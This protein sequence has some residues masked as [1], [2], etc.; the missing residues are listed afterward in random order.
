MIRKMACVLLSVVVLIVSL[1]GCGGTAVG[2]AAPSGDMDANDKFKGESI[3]LYIR[4]MDA[5]D[6]WFRDN[7]IADFQQ[8]YG[9]DVTVKTFET[10]AE[11]MHI[12]QMDE[13]KSGIGVVK[14]PESSVFPYKLGG[15]S[16]PIQ[17]VPNVDMEAIKAKY[18]ARALAAV[19]DA[20]GTWG[21]PRK[22]ENMTLVYVKSKVADAVANW[23]S[24]R[25]LIEAAFAAENGV[26]LPEGYALEADPNEWDWYDLAVVGLYWANTEYNGKTQ[27]RIAH[28]TRIYE[29]TTVELMNKVYAIGGTPDD[30]TDP[31]SSA[32]VETMKWEIFSVKNNI[33]L[34]TMWEE[35]WSGGGIWNAFASGD[36][37]LAFM[38]QMD[39]FFIHGGS[40]PDMP[41]YLADPDDMGVAIMPQGASLELK[42][43]QPAVTGSHASY[44]NGWYWMIPKTAPNP[45]LSLALIEFITS[46]KYHMAEA[47]TFGIMPVTNYVLNNLS[48]LDEP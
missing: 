1:V 29:G 28:R 8:E 25:G 4:M 22:A 2:P 27:G 45:E 33:Y 11:L 30:M 35:M 31:T 41:G 24:K 36:V 48:S 34:S 3:I 40:S 14:S 47:K 42:D 38:S 39:A 12:L 9:V 16:M 6:K 13:G 19:T 20:D 18:D 21:L 32:V 23:E 5:Q 44:S 15:Y 43:G 7:T 17:D 46:D 37:Y 26:G 10:E